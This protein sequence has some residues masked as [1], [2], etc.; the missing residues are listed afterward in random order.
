[1]FDRYPKEVDF[2]LQVLPQAADLC[3][4]I[5]SEQ[6]IEE[7]EKSDRSPVTMADFASQAWIAGQLDRQFPEDPLV[8]E[9]DSRALRQPQN[10]ELLVGV[11]GYL[12]QRQNR[13]DADQV[14]RWIDHGNGQ[15]ADRYW[16]LDPIDGTAGFLRRDQWVLALALIE[17]G[18]VVLGALACP[19]LNAGMEPIH[20]G[21]GSLVIASRDSGCWIAPEGTEDFRQLRVSART[22]P[23]QARLLGSVEP[24]HTDMTM[25]DRM[26]DQMGS[27]TELIKMDSQAKFAMVAAGQG[28]IVLRL[29]SPDRPDYREKIWDQAAGSIV[30]EEA[31]G[32]VTDLEGKPLDFSTG[33]LLT[34]NRGVVVSNGSLHEQ[35]LAALKALGADREGSAG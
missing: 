17:D 9:E 13:L 10:K 21:P 2:I 28:D 23:N 4:Q 12:R 27:Q 31:G 30:V 25:L 1:M 15:P 19:R 29:L 14:C 11:V 33:S 7:L 35:V 18:Q 5:Q 6:V 34:N 22:Q 24:S 26:R 20:E 32:K 8:A 16:T 3:R